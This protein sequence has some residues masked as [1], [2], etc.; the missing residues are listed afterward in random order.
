[1]PHEGRAVVAHPAVVDRGRQQLDLRRHAAPRLAQVLRP[2]EHQYR[3]EL[4]HRVRHPGV[5]NFAGPKSL[6]SQ[7]RSGNVYVSARQGHAI[8]VSWC[9][10]HSGSIANLSWRGVVQFRSLVGKEPVDV[11]TPGEGNDLTRTFRDADS[12]CDRRAILRRAVDSAAH[13]EQHILLALEDD[14][15]ELRLDAASYAGTYRVAKAEPIL[16]RIALAR[17]EGDLVRRAAAFSLVE[18]GG[19]DALTVAGLPRWLH[20]EIESF[21]R[22]R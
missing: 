19:E 14:D 15:E 10:S 21:K 8:S 7:P 11:C 17:D 6:P 20:R 2:H 3:L 12:G 13:A 16:V 9:G 4:H 5:L 1:M 18:L 22:S